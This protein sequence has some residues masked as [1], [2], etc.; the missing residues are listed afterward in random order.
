MMFA[1]YRRSGLLL[2]LVFVIL[3]G[4]DGPTAPS[5]AGKQAPA[6]QYSLQP[7]PVEVTPPGTIE[8]TAEG[9]PYFLAAPAADRP[10]ALFL[11]LHGLANGT[12][13][14]ARQT[15]FT[16]YGQAHHV[17]IAY[18]VGIRHAWNAGTC[19]GSDHQDDT[20]YLVAVV[21]DA[22]RHLHINP[23]RV[24][25]VGF[26]N[27]G[28]MALRAICERPDIFAAAGVMGGDLV[29]AC[30]PRPGV[31]QRPLQVRQLQGGADA[32]VPYAG[33]LSKFLGLRLPPVSNERR[34]LPPG[35][36]IDITLLPRLSH[37]W[38]TVANSGVD[39]TSLFADWLLGH[40]LRYVD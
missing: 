39:A 1:Y 30:E 11:V 25:I 13:T 26:S 2:L 15:G 37:A 31:K 17:A 38:A 28:M 32:V 23:E 22:E 40:W 29:A 20:A 9:R 12:F 27:G 24:Y 16:A 21:H 6:P 4:C 36:N 14:I 7:S 19:C 3:F 10:T 18:P 5:P 8:H 35:S 33:G 34:R